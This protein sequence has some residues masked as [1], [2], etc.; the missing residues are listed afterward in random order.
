MNMTKQTLKIYWQHA[1]RYPKYVLGLLLI[2]PTATIM[3]RII[4]PLIAADVIRRLSEQDYLPGEFWTSFQ[5]ELLLFGL[6]TI[7]GG[8][9][10]YRIDMFLAWKLETYV[11][12][13]LLRSMFNHYMKLDAGF[14]ADS[15]GGSLVS[16]ANKLVGSYIR[17]TD[18]MVFQLIPMV[19]SFS[20]V[21]VITY[22]RSPVF[23][24]AFL[25]FSIVFIVITFIL[26]KRV[27]ELSALEANAENKST[28]NLADAVTNVM[29]VKSFSSYASEKKR[30]ENV[31]EFTR[32]KALNAMWATLRRDFVASVVTS[33]IQVIAIIVA[34]MA[35]VNR[36]GDL[37]TVFL[38]LSYTAYL[39]DHLWQFQAS[40]LRNFNRSMGDAYEAVQTLLRKPLIKDPQ[41]PEKPLIEAG[42]I[43]FK[44]VVFDHE[45]LDTDEAALFDRLSFTIKP[46]EKVGLVGHSGGGKS[47]IT[48]LILRF[49]DV[50]SGVIEID[51][52]NIARLRQDDLRAYITYVPQEPVMF[53]RSLSENIAYGKQDA[54]QQEIEKAARMAHAHEFIDKLP[55]GYETLVGERGVK[56]SGGQRQRVA[57]ARAMLKDAPILLL[58]EATSALDS[59]SEKLIQDAL[60][61]LMERKTA[62]VIAHRLS[63][64]QKMDRILV[65]EN[66]EIVEEGSHQELLANNG[67][68]SELWKHQ[69]GGFLEE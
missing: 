44:D 37:A 26:G 21:M 67:I 43:V 52:Q 69:S 25:I 51:G 39:T 16:R 6:F 34:I 40:T 7:L 19:A 2:V 24:Y 30:F 15:F 22:P 57:I 3:Y 32:L 12:R 62:I 5:N 47:T 9:I 13:D 36:D 58:D 18:S 53:H 66:G 29:A 42:R 54:T 60:W 14:H 48:K 64:I 33:T 46:G 61:K 41:H 31:T 1:W 38:L 4:P 56:L 11:N 59:E 20:A 27:R 49:M 10:L 65:L 35:V 45:E 63:T 28:G 55:K 17:F 50:D 23:V 68:Y 8:V